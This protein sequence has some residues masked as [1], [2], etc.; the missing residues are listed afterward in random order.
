M[1]SS[2]SNDFPGRHSSIEACF[3]GSPCELKADSNRMDRDCQD[4]SKAEKEELSFLIQNLKSK[5]E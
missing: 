3:T 2:P 1:L 4:K 5:I